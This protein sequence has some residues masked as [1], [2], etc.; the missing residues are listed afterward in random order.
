[1]TPLSLK[2]SVLPIQN[3]RSTAD[4]YPG[5]LSLPARPHND[6]MRQKTIRTVVAVVSASSK[7]K[8]QTH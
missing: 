1:M 5:R 2:G 6:H 7:P 3:F 4:P 8:I